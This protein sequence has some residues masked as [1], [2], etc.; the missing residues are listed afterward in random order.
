MGTFSSNCITSL[1]SALCK[2]Y[3]LIPSW[4]V[5]S[6]ILFTY[7]FCIASIGSIHR[8]TSFKG[9]FSSDYITTLTS[10]LCKNFWPSLFPL[11]A[12]N[13]WEKV[14]FRSQILELPRIGEY[15][16]ISCVPVLSENVIFTFFWMCWCY[17]EAYNTGLQK[18]SSIV[19]YSCTSIWD[20][21]NTFFLHSI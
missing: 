17:S 16:N 9:T 4:T 12:V 15:W 3:W 2:N 11:W 1:T 21:K 19:Q 13:S 8:V 18:W 7:V 20:L 14:Y 10:A 6:Y 5:N